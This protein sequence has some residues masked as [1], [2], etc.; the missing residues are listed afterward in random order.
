MCGLIGI[1]SDTNIAANIIDT[2]QSLE[3]RGYDSAG[4]VVMDNEQMVSR[5]AI[6]SVDRLK[7][8]IMQHPIS[9]K[10]AIGHTRWATH[11]L[12]EIKNTHPITT[13]QTAVAHNGVI[14]NY[15]DL[16]QNLI[17]NGYEFKGDTDTEVIPNLIDYFESKGNSLIDAV[18][19]TAKKLEGSFALG[20]VSKSSPNTIIAVKNGSP[21]VIGINKNHGSCYLA[22][23]P[24]A[25]SNECSEVTHM[26]DGQIA[27]I[28]KDG[29]KLLNFNGD[30]LKINKEIVVSS[31]NHGLQGFDHFM[32]KEI[33]EQPELIRSL[34][35]ERLS[36]NNP[37]DWGSIDHVTIIACGTSMYAGY[38]A[39]YFLER[40]SDI[41]VSVEISSEFSNRSKIPMNKRDL[42][43]FVSQS[44]ETAD[45]LSALK[46]V[47]SLGGRTLGIINNPYSSMAR[48]VDES[49]MIKAGLE[50]SVAATKTFL[51]QVA[52][53]IGLMREFIPNIDELHLSIPN[54]IRKSLMLDDAVRQVVQ[55]RTLH[56][57]SII[58][59]G[60]GVCYPISLEG[61]LKIKE[62]SYIPAEGIAA[63]ELKH[64]SI[65]LIDS[66]MPVIAMIPEDQYFSKSISS[67]HEIHARAGKIILISGQDAIREVGSLCSDIIEVPSVTLEAEIPFVYTPVLQLL[68]YHMSVLKGHNVDKPRNLAKSVTVE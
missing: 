61:A 9:G 6:G 11:G 44:G 42:F 10:I 4:I 63:G 16:K 31:E 54:L 49:I 1:I 28:E 14:T 24:I 13:S 27:I 53:F 25:I 43:I 51:L 56:A 38:V 62:L 32:I 57:S 45:T 40:F 60:R 17:A 33:Y 66:D 68:A 29:F 20:I 15:K 19:L 48:L 2:L 8:K 34:L 55:K 30:E 67:V 22:S 26:E 23:D 65:A 50:I 41:R 21:L 18:I 7:S 3:Y 37:V 52:C 35:L 59:I 12:P 36:K 5:K 64:G 39:K 47:K 46:I 58:L